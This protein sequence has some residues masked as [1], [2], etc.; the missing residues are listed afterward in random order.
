M[1]T[2][3]MSGPLRGGDGSDKPHPRPPADR[4]RGLL[5]LESGQEPPGDAIG[6]LGD[7]LWPE[8]PIDSQEL[9]GA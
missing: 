2:D 7:H 1:Q 6:D 9:V 3:Q 8:H 5:L 4:Q